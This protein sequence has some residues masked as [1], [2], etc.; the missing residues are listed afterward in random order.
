MSFFSKIRGTFESL[1]SIGKNGNQI[2]NNGAA[3][4]F[5][6]P[7]DAA[8]VIARGLDP[9]AA[10]DLVTKGHFDANNNA[11]TGLTVVRMP[12]ALATKVSTVTIPD[13]ATLEYAYIRVTTAY[14]AG[15]LWNVLR[16]GDV[17]VAPMATGDS[18]PATI[19]TYQVPQDDTNWGVTGAGTV[20][21]TL[22]NVPTVGVAELV[23]AYSTPNDLT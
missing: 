19:G 14:D 22:T 20:T 3:L 13:N 18:D 8:F 16:T 21:A 1:F 2:K 15:A 9:V 6:D 12:L 17:T 7:T 10:N 11:A 23:L 5:R 4:E